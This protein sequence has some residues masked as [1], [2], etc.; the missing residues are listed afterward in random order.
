[1]KCSIFPAICLCLLAVKTA[2]AQQKTDVVLIPGFLETPNDWSF[3]ASV[4]NNTA[5]YNALSDPAI[6]STQSIAAQAAELNNFIG[7]RSP[8]NAISTGHSQGGLVARWASRDQTVLG[9]LTVGS[10]NAGAPIARQLP[11][12]FSY[13]GTL[14]DDGSVIAA[15]IADLEF[16][17]D[18]GLSIIWDDWLGIISAAPGAASLAFEN[19]INEF[20]ARQPNIQELQPTS[21]TVLSLVS[22]PGLERAASR[23]AIVADLLDYYAGS[24][25][26]TSISQQV[27]DDGM[28]AI[29][30]IGALALF[31]G[32]LLINS[33]P[34]GDENALLHQAAGFAMTEE[35]A[36]LVGLPDICNYQLVGGVPNDGLLPTSVE[37]LPDR[38]PLFT[39]AGLTHNDLLNDS[40]H[41]ISAL[42]LM[43]GR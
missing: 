12:V 27:A 18:I 41:I 29:Q 36:I 33:N 39:A 35:G 20:F 30:A 22:N 34:E 5:A 14:A 17:T 23:Q 13:L 2:Q 1:M 10:P 11:T 43:S 32:D 37:S 26:L 28:A 9:I 38:G 19:Y 3:M 24:F 6:I 16:S 31:D 42:N 15:D 40:D 8:L 7:Q 21:T 4:L 25:R